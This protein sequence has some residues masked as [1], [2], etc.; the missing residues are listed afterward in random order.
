MNSSSAV[1]C[2][3]LTNLFFKHTVALGLSIE[4]REHTSIDEM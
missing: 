4:Q 3:K 1:L 2:T